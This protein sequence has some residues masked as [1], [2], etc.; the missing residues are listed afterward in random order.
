M[1]AQTLLSAD[2]LAGLYGLH[3]SK[4][5]R[6]IDRHLIEPDHIAGRAKYFETHSLSRTLERLSPLLTVPEFI[7]RQK[8]PAN[9][10]IPGNP[11]TSLVMTALPRLTQRILGIAAA[12]RAEIARLKTEC[13]RR[14]DDLITARAGMNSALAQ[15]SLLRTRLS[16]LEKNKNAK[17]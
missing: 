3:R 8:K 16:K 12:D 15:I 10:W 14:N 6:A 13:A 11:G 9:E 17:A 4:V 7:L 2:Q 1:A 5:Y